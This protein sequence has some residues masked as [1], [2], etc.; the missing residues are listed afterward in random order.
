MPLYIGLNLIVAPF[1]IG[2]NAGA[3]AFAYRA[4]VPAAGAA[5]AHQTF[6]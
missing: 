5:T 6:A 1:A 2:L 3:T 4:L